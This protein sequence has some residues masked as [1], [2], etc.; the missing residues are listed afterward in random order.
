MDILDVSSTEFD[1]ADTEKY[2]EPA[3]FLQALWN[4]AGPSAG[5]MKIKLEMMRNKLKGKLAGIPADYA[6]MPILLVNY[7]VKEVGED[8]KDMIDYI[9]KIASKLEE[10]AEDSVKT[11]EDGE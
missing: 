4:V 3:N 7:L 8:T 10:H 1:T 9:N 11:S 6:N 5:S 2:K